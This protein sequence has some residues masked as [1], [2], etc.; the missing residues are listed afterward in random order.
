MWA[1]RDPGN[2][3]REALEAGQAR[4]A[5]VILTG[6]NS[7]FANSAVSPEC[8]F[9]QV[10]PSLRLRRATALC[11]YCDADEFELYWQPW[12]GQVDDS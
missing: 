8:R 6:G 4:L 1:A 2:L 12:R 11:P 5:D 10:T 7:L 3:S 9:P